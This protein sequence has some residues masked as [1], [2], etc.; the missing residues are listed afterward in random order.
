[1]SKGMKI[2][3]EPTIL[4]GCD[5]GIQLSVHSSMFHLSISPSTIHVEVFFSAAVIAGSMKPC[6][7][8]VLDTLFKHTP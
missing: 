2:P 6:I 7:V 5:I 1:M 4:A 3:L 8:I